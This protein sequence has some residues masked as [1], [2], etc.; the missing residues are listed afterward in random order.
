MDGYLLTLRGHL[1]QPRYAGAAMSREH[2]AVESDLRRYLAACDRSEAR[3]DA[4]NEEVERLMEPGQ[5]YE[6]FS[7]ENFAEAL[8]E[9]A[10]GE[11]RTPLSTH[12]HNK[13]P[14]LAG[15]LL[16]QLVKDYWSALATKAAEETIERNWQEMQ[17]RD[18]DDWRED[19]RDY[20]LNH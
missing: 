17:E 16:M 2:C 6:P 5:E 8:S 15:V 19:R 11:Y 9:I 20:E 18:P 13:Q 12:L 4:I 10:A 14:C 7:P 1:L 3:E